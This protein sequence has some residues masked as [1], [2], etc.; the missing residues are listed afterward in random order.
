MEKRIDIRA[1]ADFLQ[2]L[3][4]CIQTRYICCEDDIVQDYYYM[5]YD[6]QFATKAIKKSMRGRVYKHVPDWFESHRCTL[7]ELALNDLK[8]IWHR[9][10]D[11]QLQ[12]KIDA[13]TGF[14]IAIFPFGSAGD[15]PIVNRAFP[16]I[17][18]AHLDLTV[19]ELC[20]LYSEPAYADWD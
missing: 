4:A 12:E 20:E 10:S 1:R 7:S 5:T 11:E 13:L 15:R 8:N 17:T 3:F 14:A 18:A 16:L 2:R 19:N 9:D 6:K